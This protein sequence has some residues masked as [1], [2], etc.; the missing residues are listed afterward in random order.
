MIDKFEAGKWYRWTGPD[1]DVSNSSVVRWGNSKR[2]I[3]DGKPRKCLCC[4]APDLDGDQQADFEGIHAPSNLVSGWWWA[5]EW[6]E[7][8]MEVP[9]PKAC[10][11]VLLPGCVPVS[12]PGFD[13]CTTTGHI[14]TRS[15]IRRSVLD[16]IRTEE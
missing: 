9:K 2:A 14:P 1:E 4:Q 6:L 10:R 12:F 3:R 8:F 7:H 16:E 11:L 15:D 5:K 13:K